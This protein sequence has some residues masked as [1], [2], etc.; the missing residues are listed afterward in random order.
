MCLYV[1]R[2]GVEGLLLFPMHLHAICCAFMRLMCVYVSCEQQE[3]VRSRAAVKQMIKAVVK[4]ED[5]WA[6]SALHQ[7]WACNPGEKRPRQH[8]ARGGFCVFYANCCG[9]GCQGMCNMLV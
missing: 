9:G 4:Q 1:L 7:P 3:G 6:V 2:H 5:E 8:T